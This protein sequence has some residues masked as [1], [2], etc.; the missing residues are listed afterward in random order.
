MAANLRALAARCTFAVVDK[1]RSLSDELPQQIAKIDVK[2][3]GLLQ[4]LCYGVL[5]HL[6]EL[7]HDVRDF[8]KKPFSGKQ[9]VGHFLL[10]VGI[11]QIKYTRIPDHAAFN[12]TVSACKPLKCDHLKGVINGVLRNFQRQQTEQL[13]KDSQTDSRNLPAAIA[14]NHP[15]WFIKKLQSG[16]PDSWQ[17]ILN[18]NMQRPPMWVRVNVLHHSLA[19][20]LTLLADEKI[21]YSYID[22]KSS[23]IRLT[24]AVDVNKLPGFVLGWVSIQDGAAQQAARLLDCQ[25]GDNVLDCCAAPGGKTCHILEYSPQ[26]K[27][28]TAI[29]IEAAR[30]ERVQ[31]NLQRLNLK[32]QVI[33][34]DAA[35]PEQWWDGQ[36]FDRILLDAPC[37]GTGVIR[38]HPDIKWLRKYE[39]IAVLTDLQQD[40]LKNIWSLLKPG[41]TL[42]YATC[43][44]LAEENSEQVQRFLEQNSD[45]EHIAITEKIDDLGWQILPSDN[46][47]DGFYYAKL[48]KKQQ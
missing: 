16:Y 45:A 34:A 36:L 28:M 18:A 3:K 26:I 9:R 25:P 40:I 23:A 48:V 17:D 5:R 24:E 35:T 22:E 27:A 11:Y 47:M 19:Q 10:L 41:G 8:I 13:K 4:E 33:A 38:R 6:P 20:Y 7:E 1:G 15:S 30:L 32:A 12:E 42:L 37:S 43:S 31:E 21:N 14:F 44:V 39:D 2:D 46:S 29:D